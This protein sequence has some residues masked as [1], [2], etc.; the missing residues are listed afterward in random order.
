[1]IFRPLT[2]AVCILAF[3]APAA[4]ADK[5]TDAIDKSTSLY[6]S[7]DVGKAY[8]E[9]QLAVTLMGRRLTAAYLKTFP[10]APDGWK[11]R[12][13]RSTNQSALLAGQGFILNR[14]YRQDGGRGSITA[15]LIVDNPMITAMSGVFS[16]PAM[17]AR[18]QYDRVTID[19]VGEAWVKFEE[20]RNRGEAVLV[21]A[22]RIFI[23]LTARNIE[24]RDVLVTMI[25]G[26]DVAAVKKTA[27]MS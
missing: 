16:N 6:T 11:A 15:Q 23:K 10:T 1:M 7:G 18:M 19:G 24:N 27:G 26:W 21:I 4:L 14:R 20:G 5:V 22:G 12:R 13:A 8:S 9:L 2:V 17:A 3:S 25:K